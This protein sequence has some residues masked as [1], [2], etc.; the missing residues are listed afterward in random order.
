MPTWNKGYLHNVCIL[1]LTH[2]VSL[3][4]ILKPTYRLQSYSKQKGR[5]RKFSAYCG[6]QPVLK[7]NV[8]TYKVGKLPSN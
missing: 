2:T 8:D 4:S 1:E 5:R 7:V 3:Q 6:P